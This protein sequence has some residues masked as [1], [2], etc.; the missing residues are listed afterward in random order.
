MKVAESALAS[1]NRLSHPAASDNP[2]YDPTTA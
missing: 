1:A 2:E